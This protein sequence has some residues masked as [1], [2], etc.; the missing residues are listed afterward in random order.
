VKIEKGIPIPP[1]RTVSPVG[2]EHLEAM[3]VGDSI[4]FPI[5]E[6]YRAKPSM[7]PVRRSIHT[8]A[9]NYAKRHG[10]KYTIRAL[11]DEGVIRIWRIK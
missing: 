5:P 8:L 10:R 4:A 7:W 6:E 9:Q 1:R 11:S 3:A 2:K